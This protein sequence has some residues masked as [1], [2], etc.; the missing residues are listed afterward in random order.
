M[1][2]IM[3]LRTVLSFKLL[4]L[5]PLIFLLASCA[6][7]DIQFTAESPAGFWFGLWH[8]VISFIS[9]IIH[10]F[11][12]SVSVYELNNTDGWYDFGFLLGVICFWGGGSH[13]SCKSAADKKREKEWKEVGDK[14]EIKVM[15]RL[16]EWAQDEEDSD[17]REEWDEIGDKVEKRK[18]WGQNTV[19]SNIP[20]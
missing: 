15:R 12:D 1:E 13:I 6:A 18:N 10:L 8:G 7:G 11:N 16:K 4:A 9:L 2:S 19:F 14:V 17:D 5:I 3:N 20:I